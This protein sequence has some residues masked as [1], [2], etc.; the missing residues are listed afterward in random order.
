MTMTVMPEQ[1]L[2]GLGVLLALVLMWR[3]GTKRARRAA[4]KARASARVVSLAGRVIFMGTAMIGVQWLVITHP[5]NTTLLLVVLGLPDM[6]A[7]YTLTR[8]LTVTSTDI[9]TRRGG[10]RR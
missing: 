5:G 1:L 4:E 7:G 8:V 3:I 9:I 2:A 6:I 10:D